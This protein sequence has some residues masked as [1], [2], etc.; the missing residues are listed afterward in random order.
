MARAYALLGILCLIVIAGAYIAVQ[1]STIPK[2]AENA[3][4]LPAPNATSSSMA[5]TLTSPAFGNNRSIPAAYTCDGGG[6]SP[7]LDIANVPEG[8]KSLVLVMDDPDIPEAV[9]QSRGIEKFDH[10]VLYDIPADTSAIPE[11]AAGFTAGINGAG[12][13]AYIGPCPP[14]EYEPAEHRYV[15]RLYALPGTLSF[16]KAPTLDEVEA[17]AKSSATESATLTGLYQRQ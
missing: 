12:T 11:G 15:F 1:K 10:W 16:I 9:K 5:L 17:A 6:I 14:K 13:T 2:P 4:P 8:T 7:E 3:A